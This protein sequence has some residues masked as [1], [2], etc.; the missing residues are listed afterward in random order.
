MSS[1]GARN[2]GFSGNFISP[3]VKRIIFAIASNN[4]CFKNSKMAGNLRSSSPYSLSPVYQLFI[5]LIFILVLG[6]AIF[7]ALL[8]PGI[9]IFNAEPELLSDP[10]FSADK[11]DISFLRYILIVQHLSLFIIPG[12]LLIYKLKRSEQDSFRMLNIPSIRDIVYVTLLAFCLI[13]VTGI[14]GEFNSEMKLPEWLSGVET[15]MKGKEDMADRLFE[16][17]LSTGNIGSL[18]INLVMIAL[19]PAIGEELIFRGIFQRILTKMFSSGNAAVLVTATVFSAI[20]FQFYGFIPRFILGI[21]FGYLFL[22]SGTIWLPV[23][24]HFLNNAI[25]VIMS[26]LQAPE[27]TLVQPEIPIIQKIASVL[28]PILVVSIIMLYFRRKSVISSRLQSEQNL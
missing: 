13:P 16:L 9:F 19:L 11:N 28:F 14:T 4:N 8:I 18:A 3:I 7:L 20:H 17:I 5:A 10:F 6:G 15:W 27:L 1:M 24:A 25:S 23:I 2:K 12:F 21:V 22:W 26:Y